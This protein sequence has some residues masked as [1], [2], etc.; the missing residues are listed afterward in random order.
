MDIFEEK[1]D[2]EDDWFAFIPSKE[3]QIFTLAIDKLK[4]ASQEFRYIA[5]RLSLREG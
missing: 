1:N 5:E 2:L 3:Y 4:A